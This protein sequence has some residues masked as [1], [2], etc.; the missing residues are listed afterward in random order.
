MEQ[1]HSY[2]NNEIDYDFLIS[3]CSFFVKEQSKDIIKKIRKMKTIDDYNN[4]VND[5]N[6]NC[7]LNNFASV[8]DENHI[9]YKL[10]TQIININNT[11][12]KRRTIE[13]KAVK[14]MDDFRSRLNTVCS[15]LSIY[16][17]QKNIN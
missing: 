11:Y 9:M 16:K 10:Y 13:Q 17:K 3:F 7:D 12:P 8:V 14:A 4:I 2:L 1:I 6:I 5:L 15:Y